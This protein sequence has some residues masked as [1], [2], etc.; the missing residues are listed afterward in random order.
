MGFKGIPEKMNYIY[1]VFSVILYMHVWIFFLDSWTSGRAKSFITQKSDL[2][3]NRRVKC[4][5]SANG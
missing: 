3:S 1:L 4:E 2:K 5:L